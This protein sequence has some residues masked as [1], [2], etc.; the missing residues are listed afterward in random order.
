MCCWE[1][2]SHFLSGADLAARV[3][4]SPSDAGSNS[5]VRPRAQLCL[6]GFSCT[7]QWDPELPS[8]ALPC[9]GI[10]SVPCCSS[11]TCGILLCC[12]SSC[13]TPCCRG[14]PQL[15]D[16]CDGQPELV[17]GAARIIWQI[18]AIPFGVSAFWVTGNGRLGG[19][20]PGFY[21]PPVGEG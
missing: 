7:Q 4:S 12:D 5:V 16:L 11:I 8:L 21:G 15:G 19:T 6:W 2:D 1:R 9:L 18:A 17:P 14:S 13:G 10:L 20:W 3:Q